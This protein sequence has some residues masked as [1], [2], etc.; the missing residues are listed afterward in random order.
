MF[1][2]EAIKDFLSSIVDA[3]TTILDLLNPFSENF[4]IKK[5]VDMLKDLFF[6]LFVP[7]EDIFS[8][9]Y[10]KFER[11]EERRQSKSV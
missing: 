2:I 5:L 3:F 9:L 4:I 10:N 1:P 11:E 6:A 8:D 7:S